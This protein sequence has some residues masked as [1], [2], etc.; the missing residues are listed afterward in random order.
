MIS[1]S[2]QIQFADAMV[3]TRKRRVRDG[4]PDTVNEMTIVRNSRGS[5]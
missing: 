1:R 4:I 5:S 3:R 2:R